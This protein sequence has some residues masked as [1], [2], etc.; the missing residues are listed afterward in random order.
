MRRYVEALNAIV[1]AG[2]APEDA[3]YCLQ[4]PERI[5]EAQA[6]GYKAFIREMREKYPDFTQEAA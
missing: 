5:D 1:A 3:P 4:K 2:I 6:A